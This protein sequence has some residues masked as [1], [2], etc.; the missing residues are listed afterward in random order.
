MPLVR[1]FL[2]LLSQLLTRQVYASEIL[3]LEVRD[4]GKTVH[5]GLN[6]QTLSYRR[7]RT[8]H[9]CLLG[10]EFSDGLDVA[11]N[12]SQYE[13]RRK[14]QL[15]WGSELDRMVLGHPVSTSSPVDTLAN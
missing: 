8:T 6:L 10:P 5:A 15:L 11:V 1:R 4:T 3:P 2:L 7:G 9:R 13:T 12:V 14:L